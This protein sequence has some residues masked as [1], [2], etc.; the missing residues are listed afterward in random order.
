MSGDRLLPFLLNESPVRGR[1][2]RLGA[3]VDSILQAHAYPE[4]IARLL[5]ESLGMAA[6]LSAGLKTDGIVTLQLQSKGALSLLVA[7]ATAGG[8]LRGY[9]RFD[10]AA[11]KADATPGELC[12]EGFLAITLDPGGGGR[13]YQGIVPLEGESIAASMQTYFSQSQQLMVRCKLAVGQEMASGAPRW[14]VGGIYIEHI[15]E[16]AQASQENEAWREACIL[17]ETLRDDELL[18]ASLPL[19]ELL[20]RLYHEGGVWIYDP[21]PF[22][23]QCRCARDKIRRSLSGIKPAELRETAQDGQVE[24]DCHFCGR[25]ETFTLTELGVAGA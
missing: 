22:K 7:D 10:A 25:R 6:M 21:K 16:S 8:H 3:A 24:V 23:A 20:Y 4:R 15:P 13:R 19:E 2:L 9:A 18:D 11:L 12:E 5:A 14:V 17:L 1:V